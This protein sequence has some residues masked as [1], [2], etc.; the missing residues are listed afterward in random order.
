PLSF[1]ESPGPDAGVGSGAESGAESGG[2]AAMVA[3]MA[4]DPRVWFARGLIETD[5]LDAP[6]GSALG[7]E[8]E[9]VAERVLA[10]DPAAGGRLSRHGA[11]AFVQAGTRQMSRLEAV[12]SLVMTMLTHD[13]AYHECDTEWSG[14][15]GTGRACVACSESRDLEHTSAG[16]TV[17]R[18]GSQNASP[19]GQVG[20]EVS[21]AL[22]VSPTLG[23]AMVD[24]AVDQVTDLPETWARMADGSIDGYKARLIA[25][26]TRPLIE[27]VD[28]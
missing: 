8:I 25:A 11:V 17:A 23:T 4:G 15:D 21:A 1:P 12:R 5:G 16:E 26:G 14:D 13:G 2:L 10:S 20:M 22:G 28:V 19:V 6:A 18:G 3:A 24:R 9:D 27:N 7:M